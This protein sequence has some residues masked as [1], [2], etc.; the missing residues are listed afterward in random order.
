ME[1]R[2]HTS[3]EPNLLVQARAEAQLSH[4]CLREPT[5]AV[6]PTCNLRR[7]PRALKSWRRGSNTRTAKSPT[8]SISRANSSVKEDSPNATNSSSATIK[9]LRLPRSF[10]NLHCRG[11]GQN[12]SWWVRLRSTA[13]WSTPMLL[14]SCISSRTARMFTFC[15]SFVQIRVWMSYWKE[16]RDCT[17]WK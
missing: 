6:K 13:Q 10:R 1:V 5:A 16:G 7:H 2:I 8:D 15:W 11:V 12:R 3:E 9:T 4:W 14:S 17:S